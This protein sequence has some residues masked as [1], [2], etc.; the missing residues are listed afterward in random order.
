MF[1]NSLP[2][3][4]PFS[5]PN[6]FILLPPTN[7]PSALRSHITF[8]STLEKEPH[9]QDLQPRHRNHH[10]HLDQT[11]IEYPPLRAPNRTEIPVLS[12][13]EILLHPA[14]SRQRALDFQDRF[15][16]LAGLFG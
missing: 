3:D 2:L 16:E 15:F 7:P 8:P 5:R 12:R 1:Y 14:H 6:S 11:E 9:H 13:P 10:T 4:N